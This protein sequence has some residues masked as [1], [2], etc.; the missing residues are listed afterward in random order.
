MK[1][2]RPRRITL[3]PTKCE[4]DCVSHFSSLINTQV[5]H[6]SHSQATCQGIVH[7]PLPIP[8]A[9]PWRILRASSLPRATRLEISPILNP[10]DPNRA[11]DLRGPLWPSSICCLF[12]QGMAWGVLWC[13]GPELHSRSWKEGSGT[14]YACYAASN[15]WGGNKGGLGE[16]LLGCQEEAELIG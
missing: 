6:K 4:C 12:W 16:R 8:R 10:G 15:W 5:N 7:P 11:W 13:E 9:L 2:V 3:A 1:L 14:I